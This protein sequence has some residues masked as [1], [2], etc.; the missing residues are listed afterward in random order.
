MTRLDYVIKRWRAYQHAVTDFQAIH[1]P[2]ANPWL[3]APALAEQHCELFAALPL[4]VRVAVCLRA[5]CWR[6]AVHE[7]RHSRK[8]VR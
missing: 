7:V 5:R 2:G 4:W 6:D 3:V 1:G 8:A